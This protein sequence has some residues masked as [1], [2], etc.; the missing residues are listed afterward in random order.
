MCQHSTS[1]CSDA[2]SCN[3][4]TDQM[5]DLDCAGGLNYKCEGDKIKVEYYNSAT[6]GGS[7][8]AECDFSDMS[9][10]A[11]CTT[12]TVCDCH[13][14]YTLGTCTE[15]A[16]IVPGMGIYMKF[17]GTCPSGGGGDAPCFSREAEAC[18]VLDSSASPTDAHRACFDEPALQT[19]ERVKMA[20]LSGGDLVLSAGKDLTYEVAR[21][22]VNQHRIE[23][24]V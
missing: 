22:I 21:V 17:T 4:L 8:S 2:G 6:C 1:D 14:P 20:D 19:A 5:L 24:Q 7:V 15:Y 16:S 3:T 13:F 23:G 12:G 18:R 11:S 9:K 10:Y